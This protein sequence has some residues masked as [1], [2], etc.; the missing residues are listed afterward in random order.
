MSQ[1]NEKMKIKGRSNLITVVGI[2]LL[3][4]AGSVT[5]SIAQ[6]Q[7]P[8]TPIGELN[9]KQ[10]YAD[11]VI[12]QSVLNSDAVVQCSE[13][14]FTSAATLKLVRDTGNTKDALMIPAMAGA[15]IVHQ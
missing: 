3:L 5:E 6:R 7:P 13:A 14:L 8:Q 12:N 10:I 2:L 11:D 15:W 4:I 1:R 9:G